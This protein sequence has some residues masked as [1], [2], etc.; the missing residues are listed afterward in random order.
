MLGDLL[1]KLFHLMKYG[2]ELFLMK[3]KSL[4]KDG[5][6]FIYSVINNGIVTNKTNYIL[7][8]NDIKKVF[9]IM[10]VEGPGRI[11][12]LVRGPAYIWA[13]LN[14]NRIVKK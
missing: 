10:P 13:I 1:W 7:S 9:N 8:K 11:N 3:D 6:E 12:D 2:I 5:K 4:N 14:D